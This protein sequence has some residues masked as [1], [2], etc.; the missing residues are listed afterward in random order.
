[1]AIGQ[2]HFRAAAAAGCLLLA[3]S[4]AMARPAGA[5]AQATAEAETTEPAHPDAKAILLGMARHLAA[6]P[7][8]GVSLRSGYDVV[9][10]SGQKIEFNEKRKLLVQR[11]DRLR[12]EIEHSD[13]DRQLVL[14][15][16][17]DITVASTPQ[18]VYAQAAKP[19]VLD[20]AVAYFLRDLR[21]RLPLA[22]MLVNELPAELERRIES[23]DYVEETNILGAPAHHLA[24]RTATVDA[25]FWVTT[26][27]KPLPLRV[28]LTYKTAGGAPQFWSEFSD[29]NLA[30]SAPDTAFAFSVPQGA[31]KIPFLTQVP[32]I[33]TGGAAASV[34]RDTRPAQDAGERP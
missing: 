18:N 11:P 22:L 32:Q 14:F 34:P 7:A 19:G 16:G 5:E 10:E 28:V 31:R 13:G 20:D 24:A 23:V 8:F 25:Q 29:W 17:Q 1:M 2:G 27:D 30:P 21:M 12:V 26:G 15:D 3:L 4:G 33:A 6:A 9:Q